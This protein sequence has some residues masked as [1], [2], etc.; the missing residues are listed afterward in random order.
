M[1]GQAMSN[2][3]EDV[4]AMQRIEINVLLNVFLHL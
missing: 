4:Y 2:P 3:G 1:R